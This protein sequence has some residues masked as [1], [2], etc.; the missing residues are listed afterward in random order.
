MGTSTTDALVEMIHHWCEDTDRCGTYVRNHLLDF[1][2]AFDFIIHEKVLVK[3]KAIDVPPYILY[4]A[5][6]ML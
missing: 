4:Q 6:D 1:A 5:L 3:L 2:K